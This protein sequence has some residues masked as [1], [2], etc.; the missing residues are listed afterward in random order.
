MYLTNEFSK[1]N[2]IIILVLERAF[3]AYDRTLMHKED[4]H[5]ALLDPKVRSTSGCTCTGVIITHE[6]VIAFNT[7]DSRTLLIDAPNTPNRDD[8][9]KA[10]FVKVKT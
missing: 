10:A 7:G 8:R 4:I 6:H 9:E 3:P 5:M 2:T 1:I